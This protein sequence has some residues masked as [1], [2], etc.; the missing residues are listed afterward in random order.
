MD[1]TRALPGIKTSRGTLC[2]H[3][4]AAVTWQGQTAARG[5]PTVIA[6]AGLDFK[7]MSEEMSDFTFSA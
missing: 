5:L 1:F 3:V 2:A 4:C 6:V 7:Y